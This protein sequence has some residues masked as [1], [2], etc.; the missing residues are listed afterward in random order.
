MT[1]PKNI[2]IIAGIG[3]MG[4]F[5]TTTIRLLACVTTPAPCVS[6]PWQAASRA[7]DKGNAMGSATAKSKGSC[8]STGAERLCCGYEK[9]HAPLLQFATS[10]SFRFPDFYGWFLG[11]VLSRLHS[12]PLTDRDGYAI[13]LSCSSAKNCRGFLHNMVSICSSVAPP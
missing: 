3:R 7:F 12:L 2:F 11:K 1:F 9:P 5:Y 8:R 10:L 6:C 13:G 4:F